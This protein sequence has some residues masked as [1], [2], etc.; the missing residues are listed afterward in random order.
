M[1]VT[2]LRIRLLINVL[3]LLCALDQTVYSVFLRVDPNRLQFFEYEP[4]TLHCEGV[5]GEVLSCRTTSRPASKQVSCNIKNVFPEDS[6]EYWCEAEGGE[7]SNSVDIIVTAGSVILVSPA[8][9]VMEG[10]AVTLSCRNK[11]ASFN[12]QADFYKNGRLISSSSTGEMTLRSVFKSDEGLY[13]CSISGA[14]ESPQ[15]WLAVRETPISSN[16]NSSNSTP[17]IVV[18]VLLMLLLLA[19]GLHLGKGYLHRVLLYL[20][21][22]TPESR[23]PEDQTVSVETGAAD[24]NKVT[25][26]AVTK[27]RRKKDEDEFASRPIYYTLGLG[28]TQH[29]EHAAGINPSFTENAVYSSIELL[30]EGGALK[31]MFNQFSLSD[32]IV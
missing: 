13:K 20:S 15:S 30:S 28:D 5:K 29:L 26:A 14:G 23:L 10:E 18:S 2:A 3:F 11:T 1:E 27:N 7:R 31:D 12:L 9:P 19:V 22:L 32:E 16:P 25:Y 6:G 17:W 21:T 24:A 8:L 4:V